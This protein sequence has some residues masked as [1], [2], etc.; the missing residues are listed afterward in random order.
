MSQKGQRKCCCLI[1][2]KQSV[3]E[4]HRRGL[5]GQ[6]GRLSHSDNQISS[7]KP[8]LSVQSHWQTMNCSPLGISSGPL[9][10]PPSSPS[11]PWAIPLAV[12]R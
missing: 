5:S 7:F 3:H 1:Q 12:H 8:W 2:S 10:P 11:A 4:I 6:Q 9:L